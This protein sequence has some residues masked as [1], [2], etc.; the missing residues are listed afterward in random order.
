[1]RLVIFEALKK[2]EKPGL[3][4]GHYF[5]ISFLTRFLGVVVPPH[6]LEKFPD[7]MTIAVQHQFRSLKV[8]NDFFKI[9]LRFNGKYENLIV[10]Y[11]SITSFADPSMK[12]VLKF[13]TNYD[14]ISGKDLEN[15]SDSKQ[16][17]SNFVEQESSANVDLSAKVIS[18]DVFRKNRN[19]NNPQDKS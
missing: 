13:T 14:D 1:M 11:K 5:I 4:G 17:N 7:E 3:P 19:T 18:I 15:Y 12:F 10:P 8:E 9:S 16:I 6:L 2:V